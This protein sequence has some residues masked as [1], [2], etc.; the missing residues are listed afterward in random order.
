MKHR[1]I[2][3]CA[4][5]G[6]GWLALLSSQSFLPA[7]TSF[8]TPLSGAAGADWF[9][10]N[11]MDHGDGMTP[12]DYAGGRQT[13]PTHTGIDIMLYD[14]LTMDQG[15]DVLAAA[16]GTVVY[17]VD[18][19]DDRALENQPNSIFLRHADGS[20]SYYAHL[21]KNSLL[22]TTGQVVALGQKIA[23]LGANGT[24]D[25]SHLHFGAL[26]RWA[27]NG[28]WCEIMTNQLGLSQGF[29]WFD[30]YSNQ[31]I[32]HV[33]GMGV[34]HTNDP[35]QWLPA[36]RLQQTP[37]S[38]SLIHSGPFYA[39]IKYTG[40]RTN[41]FLAIRLLSLSGPGATIDFTPC[42]WRTSDYLIFHMLLWQSDWLNASL[43][44]GTTY[45]LQYQWNGGEWRDGPGANTFTVADY[46]QEVYLSRIS[47]PAWSNAPVPPARL[48][49][50]A[51]EFTNGVRLA[52]APSS[53]SIYYIVQRDAGGAAGAA[54]TL[55]R[56]SSSG[57]DDTNAAAE[58]VYAYR[59]AAANAS[60]TG[61]CSGA[62]AGWSAEPAGTGPDLRINQ[63][64][65][66]LDLGRGE[67]VAVTVQL[68]PGMYA[69]VEADWWV[70]A[71]AN[72]AWYYL[73]RSMEW[74]WFNGNLDHCRPVLQGPL[75]HAGPA[76]V[77]NSAGLP[78]GYFQFWFAV[79][80]R[81]GGLNVHGPIL[82]DSLGV[83]IR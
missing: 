24:N 66:S 79:D 32:G 22:V 26:D 45:K 55:V 13:Y 27:T 21:K 17:C 20:V 46:R 36:W 23:D 71:L 15:I 43:A 69:G 7:A 19:L 38:Y 42:G 65:R 67:W 12:L 57:Y 11:F 58:T 14:Y 8:E 74:A 78:A 61:A 35:V 2:F 18:G 1:R 37:S 4:K 33:I 47:L 40:R 83:T 31:V 10:I 64:H 50:S 72:G 73:D 41:D 29:D 76:T 75:F 34:T 62:V 6:I 77:L 9:V 16:P 51:G 52:W 81:D 54:A 30:N 44:D 60:G 3:Q 80:P 53:N 49:A 82:Y 48:A 25:V 68:D 5:A 59:V 70:V 39:W 28:V 56:T 63:R